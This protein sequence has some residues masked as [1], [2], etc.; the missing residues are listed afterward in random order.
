[1]TKNRSRFILDAVRHELERQR[2]EEL[3]QSLQNPH[4]ESA[5]VAELGIQ[6]WCTGLPDDS[7]LVDAASGRAVR[8][9][10]DEGWS[11]LHKDED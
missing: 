5:Q 11:T 8:W 9:S 1:M 2:R 3:R 4:E 7:D 6:D 10:A